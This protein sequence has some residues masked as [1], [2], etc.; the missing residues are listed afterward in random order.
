MPLLPSLGDGEG[1][2]LSTSVTIG[3]GNVATW[4][5]PGFLAAPLLSSLLLAATARVDY[6]AKGPI[7]PIARRGSGITVQCVTSVLLGSSVAVPSGQW[8][9]YLLEEAVKAAEQETT[10]NGT[11]QPTG[12][13]GRALSN[14]VMSTVAAASWKWMAL[15]A[16]SSLIVATAMGCSALL[17]PETRQVL[18]RH[19]CLPPR[20][21]HRLLCVVIVIA[22]PTNIE[23]LQLLPWKFKA[24]STKHGV[25]PMGGSWRT[26]A[27]RTRST[28]M[29]ATAACL[30]GTVPLIALQLVFLVRVVPFSSEKTWLLYTCALALLT[31]AALVVNGVV[32]LRDLLCTREARHRLD[33]IE[34]YG[35]GRGSGGLSSYLKRRLT[36]SCV[37]SMSTAGGRRVVDDVVATPDKE[38][39][40][41]EVSQKRSPASEAAVCGMRTTVPD[42]KNCTAQLHAD[43][44]PGKFSEYVLSPA[45][46]GSQPQYVWS[47]A[48]TSSSPQVTPTPETNEPFSDCAPMPSTPQPQYVWSPA[49]TCSSPQIT[50]TPETSKSFSV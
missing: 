48:G 2:L 30:L 46:T 50:P 9:F 44:S 42:Y 47:Q 28:L 39:S 10:L 32:R 14:D 1:S 35:S 5:V 3:S 45:G 16:L 15:A 26:V 4:W 11:E 8:A 7:S 33:T 18:H 23:L 24:P 31:T 49:G 19:L 6:H 37:P 29:T 20:S 17:L 34:D 13:R 12:S 36:S 43:S 41:L 21:Q 27:Q 22:L 25:K 38:D 40:T